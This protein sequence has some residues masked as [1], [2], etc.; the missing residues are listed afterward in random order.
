MIRRP[1]GA[2][3]TDT[4]FPSTTLFRSSRR[5]QPGFARG[6]R[7]RLRR[8]AGPHPAGRVRATGASRFPPASAVLAKVRSPSLPSL[9]RRAFGQV[10]ARLARH[11]DA[12]LRNDVLLDL[13]GPPADDQ[14]ALEHVVPLPAAVLALV[15]SEEHTSELQSLMR[16]SSADFCFQ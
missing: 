9:C 2:T 13:G 3:R 4:L 14:A 16:I 6:L 8:R 15:S 11:V 10:Q 7:L 5:A 12:S 1:P